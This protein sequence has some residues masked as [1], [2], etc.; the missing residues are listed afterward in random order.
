MI[1][2]HE[3]ENR[4]DA[5]RLKCSIARTAG[6]CAPEAAPGFPNDRAMRNLALLY[7]G[8]SRVTGRRSEESSLPFSPVAPDDRAWLRVDPVV[9]SVRLPKA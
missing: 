1:A 3:S 8:A 5:E 2:L 7:G 9:S 6:D 4:I